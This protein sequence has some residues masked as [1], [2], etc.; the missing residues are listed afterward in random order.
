M[1]GP[2]EQIRDR[3]GDRREGAQG[4]KRMESFV[5]G[6]GADVYGRDTR[7]S[8]DAV[9]AEGKAGEAN[10]RMPEGCGNKKV[11]GAVAGW[12]RVF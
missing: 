3:N 4:S 1:P 11:L 2:A 7:R 9:F 12:W 10:P 6:M 8:E 5:D